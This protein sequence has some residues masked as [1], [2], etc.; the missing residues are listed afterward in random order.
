MLYATATDQSTTQPSLQKLLLE[1]DGNYQNPQLN[2]ME[3]V[4]DFVG[5]VLNGNLYQ[6]PKAPCKR[7]MGKSLRARGIPVPCTISSL[8]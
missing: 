7:G 2:N 4:G 5:S 1:V 3:K 6:T 8:S